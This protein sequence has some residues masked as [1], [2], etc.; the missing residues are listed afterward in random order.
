MQSVQW[1]WAHKDDPNIVKSAHAQMGHTILPQMLS[2]VQGFS[3]AVQSTVTSLVNQ[4]VQLSEA[5][6]G[7]LGGITGVPLLS[8]AQS[9][10]QAVSNGVKDLVT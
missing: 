5:V 4:A 1:L 7:L 6:L 10:V 9:L 8:A 2:A 3:Q